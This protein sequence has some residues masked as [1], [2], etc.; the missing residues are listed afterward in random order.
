[1]SNMLLAAAGGLGIGGI[2]TIFL[3]LYY[4]RLKLILSDVLRLCGGMG[5]WFRKKSLETEVE[6]AINLFTKNFNAELTSPLLPGC[7]VEWV[8]EANQT[9]FVREGKAIVRLSFSADN[10]DLNLY[11]AIHAYIKTGALQRTK[12]YIRKATASAIDLLLTRLLIFQSGRRS[13]LTI[14]NDRF[15]EETNELKAIFYKL[16]ET[17]Y[18][19]L[20]KPILLQELHFLGEVIGE[21]VPKTAYEEE[22]ERFLEWLYDL[23]SREERERSDLKFVGEHIKVGVI[24]VASIDTYEK[25]GLSPYLRRAMWYATNDFKCIYLCSRGVARGNITKQIAHDLESKSGF[26]ILT[27]R[28]DV[29]R[30]DSEGKDLKITCIALKPDLTTIVHAAWVR[31]QSD[32]DAGRSTSVIVK[33]ITDDYLVVDAEGLR[34]EIT[35]KNAS[36]LGIPDLRRYF[37]QEQELL[38]RIIDLNADN[39][40]ITLSNC[41]TDTDPKKLIESLQASLDT[42]LPATVTR[43]ITAKDQETGVNVTLQGKTVIGYLPRAALTYSRFASISAKFPIGSNLTVIPVRVDISHKTY[44]CRL[45][46]LKDPWATKAKYAVGARVAATI[47]QVAERRITFEL[48]EGVEGFVPVSEISWVSLEENLKT[49]KTYE[50]GRTVDVTITGIDENQQLFLL[51]IKRLAKNPVEDY[52]ELNRNVNI[53]AT[54]DTVSLSGA[55]VTVDGTSFR[56]FVPASEVLWGYC[57]DVRDYMKPGSKIFVRPI[58]YDE[59]HNNIILSCKRS[60]PNDFDEFCCSHHVGDAVIGCPYAIEDDK[61]RIKINFGEGLATEA[62]VHKSQLSSL[63][64]IDEKLI[65]EILNIG[66]DYKFLIK[67]FDEVSKLVELS[68][69][70]YLRSAIETLSYGTEYQAKIISSRNRYIACGDNF[71]GVLIENSKRRTTYPKS[72][73][74]ILAKIDREGNKVEVTLA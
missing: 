62:Y 10:H 49:I 4:P 29:I 42:T 67:R 12:P 41:D 16:E 27:K 33:E 71:E 28:P 43:I 24:L 7:E 72:S 73:T 34:V 57:R 30:H 2:I 32:C 36:S 63:V 51:S 17:E 45:A 22:A 60:T 59:Y 15:N 46:S 13:L 37:E 68:R 25:H 40:T 55:E 44:V 61:I 66:Q 47:R 52:F 26:S 21:K 31:L 53:Q 39:Q 8:T 50:V 20:F 9:N 69:K 14:L 18:S 19:G 48:E 5:R 23:A 6:G 38:V 65:R 3:F 56:G 11:N 58:R 74:V 54:V 64:F 35:K 70:E 1:M